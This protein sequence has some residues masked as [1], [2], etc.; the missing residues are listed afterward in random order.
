MGAWACM[1]NLGGVHGAGCRRST[2]GRGSEVQV[3]VQPI[4]IRDVCRDVR[5]ISGRRAAVG[6][7]ELLCPDKTMGGAHDYV[8]ASFTGKR[9]SEMYRARPAGDLHMLQSFH[10]S[11]GPVDKSIGLD[12]QSLFPEPSTHHRPMLG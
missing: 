2:P 11:T 5:L 6:T 9:V 10:W 8:S 12:V 7:G 3:Q 4:Q 1:G